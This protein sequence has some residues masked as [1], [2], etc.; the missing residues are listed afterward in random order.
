MATRQDSPAARHSDFYAE[1]RTSL[2]AR[3][4]SW[5][6]Q[7]TWR[8]FLRLYGRLIYSV[9]T[10]AGLATQEAEDA[11]QETVISVA[12]SMPAFRYDPA[13]CSFKTWLRHLAHKRIADQFRRRLPTATL[14]TGPGSEAAS[15]TAPLERVPDPASRNLDAIWDLEWQQSV[16]DAAVVRAKNAVSVA[17]YQ[18]FDLHVLKGWKVKQVCSVLGVNAAQVYLAKHRVLRQIKHE[19]KRLER[20]GV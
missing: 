10:Q 13:R 4:K 9:A 14:P 16:F 5:D 6:D 18:I 15:Q 7:E 17:Q 8:D 3:L 19:A 2:V 1:T 11:V 20:E 12:K